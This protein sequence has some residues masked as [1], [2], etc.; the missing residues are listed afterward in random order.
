MAAAPM[1][2]NAISLTA[3]IWFADNE[4][5]IAGALMTL[6]SP[7]GSLVSFVI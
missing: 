3:N 2:L 6:A 4:R 7:L 5:A 1:Y